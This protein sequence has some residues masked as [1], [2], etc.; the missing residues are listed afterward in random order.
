MWK[1]VVGYEGLYEVSDSGFVRSKN[2]IDSRNRFR[3]GCLLKDWPSSFG[4]PKVTLSKE[5]KKIDREV[6]LLV[7]ESFIGP[8]PDGLFGLHKNDNPVD[9]R[10]ENL[11]YGSRSAN[12][13]DAIRNGRLD[14]SKR[15][16]GWSH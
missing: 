3:E 16:N 15:R 5:G 13:L 1:P 6:H 12:V 11:Y 9:C 10:L 8:R 2:R 14:Y 4:Y 7:L